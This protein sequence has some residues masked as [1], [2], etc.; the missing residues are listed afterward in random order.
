MGT[1]RI[2]IFIVSRQVDTSLVELSIKQTEKNNCILEIVH[3]EKLIDEEGIIIL[4]ITSLSDHLFEK[5]L[6]YSGQT[7][8]PL[9]IV[10]ENQDPFFIANVARLNIPNIFIIPF[11]LPKF[12]SHFKKILE[13]FIPD[14][15][16]N[17]NQTDKQ[18][19]IFHNIIGK[20]LRIQ[21]VFDISKKIAAT[22]NINILI[23]GETGTGKGVLAKAI[24][25][26]SPN[27]KSPFIDINCSALPANLLETE[28]FGHMPG[29]FTDAKIAKT[30]LFELAQDG[31]IFLDEIG[32]LS[33]DLQVKLLRAIDNRVIRRLGGTYDIPIKARI[34]SATNRNLPQ[35]ILEE[36]FRN[37]LY[38]RL[39][40]INIH[41][42]P[43]R[44]RGNDVVEISEYLI[45]NACKQFNKPV[46]QITEEL[47]TFLL[48][49][50]WPGNIRE[51]KNAIERAV[52]LSNDDKLN[53]KF[54]F[55]ILTPEIESAFSSKSE[56][57]ILSFEI[58][59][60][61]TTLQDFSSVYVRKVLE[62][63]YGNKSKTAKLLGLSRPTL[64]KILQNKS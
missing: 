49:Y 2:K 42:P 58:D 31:T 13:N 17:K 39:N 57:S 9:I 24:H 61:S 11:E 1:K 10:T 15:F 26:L 28:L 20:S 38:H 59:F 53:V 19:E 52:L 21:E 22:P 29:A 27:Y 40:A 54:L 33:L 14:I 64:D 46:F 63:L 3:T 8:N 41:M 56:N 7:K 62:R 44:D 12:R 36:K 6:K 47:R 45:N 25:D 32:D 51:L 4:G 23:T 37:D 34:I 30:G 50:L 18:E 55:N 43:L 16:R 60:N 5:T 48:N 35:L